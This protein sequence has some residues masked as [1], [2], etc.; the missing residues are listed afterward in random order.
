MTATAALSTYNA[1]MAYSKINSY[2]NPF[3]STMSAS[4]TDY[5]GITDT[6]SLSPQSLSAYA[7]NWTTEQLFSVTSD[8]IDGK[9]KTLNTIGSEYAE[10]LS[11][12]ESFAGDLFSMAGVNLKQPVTLQ[13]DGIGHLQQVGTL[14]DD[15]E[16]VSGVLKDTPKL[17][18]DF[19]LIAAKAS[20]L[21]AAETNPEFVADYNSSPSQT[22][23][24]Y[25]DVLKD[26]M[27][28]FQV[29]LSNK[30]VETGFGD[31]IYS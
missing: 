28:S 5:E 3:S 25:E 8:T 1:Q 12:F 13:S 4:S 18:S 10:E 15:S 7:R 30:G 20:I 16:R 19:M 9:Y 17:T 6:V 14:N 22:M 21:Q 26:Y 2:R 24:K 23:E 31:P 27:L 11:A 29:T